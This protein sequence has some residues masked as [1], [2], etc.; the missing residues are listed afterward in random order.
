V[1]HYSKERI[2]DV[3]ANRNDVYNEFRVRVLAAEADARMAAS[4]ATRP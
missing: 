4:S 2:A 3:A 1:I